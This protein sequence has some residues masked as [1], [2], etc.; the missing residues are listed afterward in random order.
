VL[1]AFAEG[2]FASWASVFLEE[3]RHV[4][5]ELAALALS[6]FWAAIVA[7]RLG[8]AALVP[9]VGAERIWLALLVAM[10]IAFLSLPLVAGATSG[11]GLFVLAGLACSS[12]FPLT[13]GLASRSTSDPAR[14]SSLLVAALMLGVGTSSFALGALRERLSLEAIYRLSTLYPL[15][16]LALA[17]IALRSAR[18]RSPGIERE[19]PAPAHRGDARHGR[20]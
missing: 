11:I 2:T 13:V 9:H 12:F 4:P 6:G 17:G 5:A 14:A 18:E 1:Y 10:V 8:T 3:D 16:A 15:A 19:L 7:G 20:P